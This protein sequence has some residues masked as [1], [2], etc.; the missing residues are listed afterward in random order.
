MITTNKISQGQLNSE[1]SQTITNGVTDK[2]PSEDAVFDALA[3]KSPYPVAEWY[4]DA[5]AIS[6]ADGGVYYS[7][8]INNNAPETVSTYRPTSTKTNFCFGSSKFRCF[9]RWQQHFL[10][11]SV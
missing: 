11:W 8:R 10:R 5:T 9:G 4:S 7:G 3:L 6:P 2:A 1:V